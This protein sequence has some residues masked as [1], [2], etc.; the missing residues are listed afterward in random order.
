VSVLSAC[1]FI[2]L[3]Q[4]GCDELC[5]ANAY[6]FFS[7]TVVERSMNSLLSVAS[8]SKQ[9]EEQVANRSNLI[10][11]FMRKL[12]ISNTWNSVWFSIAFIHWVV[13]GVGVISL[14]GNS[15]NLCS[16]DQPAITRAVP[17]LALNPFAY[18][19]IHICAESLAAAL[20]LWAML[21]SFQPK[22]SHSIVSLHSFPKLR[23][24]TTP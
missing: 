14:R 12:L 22:H 8:L 23:Q 11:G 24:Q 18:S 16:N 9:A 21:P 19:C 4:T 7:Y 2:G 20:T 15:S 17:F 13:I 3:A 5:F 6:L 1:E 10:R